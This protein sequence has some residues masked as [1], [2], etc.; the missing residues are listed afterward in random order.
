MTEKIKV[1]KYEENLAAEYHNGWIVYRMYRKYLLDFIKKNKDNIYRPE[2][3]KSLLRS[4]P[5]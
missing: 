1:I 2:S 4:K 5:L 3:L